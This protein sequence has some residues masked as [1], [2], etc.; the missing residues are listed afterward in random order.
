MMAVVSYWQ[1]RLHNE[2]QNSSV[3]SLHNKTVCQRTGF[4]FFQGK[5]IMYSKTARI[6][7][8]WSKF[9]REPEVRI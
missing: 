9:K 5:E 1:I 4:C 3:A 6:C 2:M 8:T 7:N